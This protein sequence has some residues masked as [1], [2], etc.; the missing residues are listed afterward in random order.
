MGLTKRL[1]LGVVVLV[2][3]LAVAIVLL[4]GTRLRQRLEQEQLDELTREARFVATQW[5]TGIDA[6]HLADSAGTAL[7]RRVTIIDSTGVVRGDSEF[8]GPALAA[9]ENHAT[10]PEV[11]MA[12]GAGVGHNQRQSHSAGDEELYVA[13]RHPLGFVRVSIG[14][15]TLRSIVWGAQRDVLV[16]S[17]LA[18]FGALV[19]A[20]LFSRSVSRP[21]IELRDVAR[22]IADGDLDRRPALTAPGEVGDLALAL[23]RMAEQLGLRLEALEADEAL[24]IAVV[25]ALAQGL[26]VIDRGGNVVRLNRSARQLLELEDTV[27]FSVDR[28]PREGT[29]VRDVRSAMRGTPVET[30]EL[31]IGSRTL[32]LT[33]R[34]LADG[35]AVLALMDLT[36]RRRLETIRRDFVANVSHELKTPL[37]VINGFAETLE[38][39]NLPQEDR[40]RFAATIQANAR[41][42][43]RIVDDLLD[44]SRYESG[45]WRPDPIAVDVRATTN[46]VMTAVRPAAEAKGIALLAEIGADAERVWADPTALRQILDNLVQN[47]VR[48]TNA[49]SV[50]LFSRRV[51]QGILIGVRDTGVGIP[52]EHLPRI[53]ER[54]YR[55]DPS[56]SR[57][58]G[59]TGLGLAIVRHLAEAHGGA[60]R[61]ES[62]VGVG[63][64]I[65]VLFP[66]RSEVTT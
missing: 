30:S 60:V 17:F 58:E 39:S 43:Q 20:Y 32:A 34:P 2:S 18:L 7:R 36:T 15:A 51:G 21:V 49:G 44:L 4:A 22:A 28:L 1:L 5:R 11:V 27:P 24:L 31:A 47:A 54:F 55:V 38:D 3:A 29:L 23:H 65:A 14:T 12:R 33:A 64:T 56:R 8:D 25:E 41:R 46:D 16:A 6:D 42:M 61:A 40:H 63:T 45:A 26:V 10:R 59:G 52:T 13:V 35:G 50:T 9:L 53:F 62:T 19:L 66:P 37:T 48:Y 57:D